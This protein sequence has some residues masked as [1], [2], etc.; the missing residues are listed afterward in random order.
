MP[1]ESGEILLGERR[2]SF[3]VARS[4]RRRRTIAFVM[5]SPSALKITAPVRASLSSIRAVIQKQCGWIARRLTEFQRAAASPRQSQNFRDGENVLYMGKAHRLSVTQDKNLPQGCWLRPHRFDANLHA[6]EC[7]ASDL[8]QEVRLEIL[9]WLKKRARAKLKKRMDLWARRLG[10]NYRRLVI[11]NAERRW[12]SCNVQNVIRLNWRL[13]MA[14]LP[15][16]DYVVVH[17]LCH[18]RHKN[19]GAQFWRQVASVIP[20]HRARRK[21]LRLM[22]D[23]LRV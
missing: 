6:E 10:V 18:I 4:R 9:L 13:V 12:G 5:E 1:S 2:I 23:G 17:E 8:Q 15:I 16:L 20:D 21:Q 11:T 3:T 19:H 7:G 22:G 14:P